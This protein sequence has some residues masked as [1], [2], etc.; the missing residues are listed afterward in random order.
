MTLHTT[1]SQDGVYVMSPA[2]SDTAFGQLMSN[3]AL[4]L[5]AKAAALPSP[6]ENRS[7]YWVMVDASGPLDTDRGTALLQALVDAKA[8]AT[9]FFGA[10]KLDATR[11]VQVLIPPGR[12]D[13]DTSFLDMSQP[14]LDLVGFDRDTTVISSSAGNG[15]GVGTVYQGADNTVISDLTLQMVAG[16]VSYN[17]SDAAAYKVNPDATDGYANTVLRRV[18]L[19]GVA[20]ISW[21][22]GYDGVYAGLYEDVIAEGVYGFFAS[23]KNTGRFERCCCFGM[24]GFASNNTSSSVFIDCEAAEGGWYGSNNDGLFVRCWAGDNGFGGTCNGTFESCLAGQYG[25]GSNVA[26]GRFLDCIGGDF[27]FATAQ[28]GCQGALGLFVRCVGGSASFGGSSG[29][30]VAVAAGQ[31]VDCVGGD[32]SFGYPVSSMQHGVFLRCVGGDR[33]FDYASVQ[34]E[35]IYAFCVGGDYSFGGNSSA[36]A[37]TCFYC[38]A[39]DYSFGQ[40]SFSQGACQGCVGGLASFPGQATLAR[41]EGGL[42]SYSE[43][44]FRYEC[45]IRGTHNTL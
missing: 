34:G 5:A 44:T 28:P 35:G 18:R 16:S 31:F 8:L 10:S 14:Y 2:V 33:S 38:V 43:S 40:Y 3:F 9:A 7:E 22:P 17:P 13:L 15:T 23:G 37:G 25:F 1:A 24:Y 42:G 6:V 45:S 19:L 39:G 26:G 30:N 20:S 29:S 21:A 36:D 11:H 41:C 27:S 32:D 12:Y 4:L